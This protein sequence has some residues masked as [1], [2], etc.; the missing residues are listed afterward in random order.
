MII[1]TVHYAACNMQNTKK[2]A[3]S[4]TRL[5]S[6]NIL[7]CSSVSKCKKLLCS[8]IEIKVKLLNMVVTEEDN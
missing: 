5:S 7:N 1:Y 8:R 6:I 2:S 4:L 3:V